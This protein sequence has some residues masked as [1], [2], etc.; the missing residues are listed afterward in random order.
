MPNLAK[1]V[2]SLEAQVQKYER[3][4]NRANRKLDQFNRKQTKS[5]DA[6]KKSFI[7]LGAAAG[8][9][10][11]GAGLG[12]QIVRIE[13]ATGV[14]RAQLETATGS[15]EGA[16]DAFDRL[17][18][19]AARTP[20]ALEESI[21][22]FTRLVNLGLTPS[23]RALVSYGNTAAAT[24]K[25]ILQFVEA[26][27]DASVGEFER[28]K[29]FGIKAGKEGDKVTFRFRGLTTEVGNSISEIENFLIGLGETEFGGGLERRIETLDGKLSN[30]GDAWDTLFRTISD[31][32]IGD[33]IKQQV[34]N[35]ISAIEGLNRALSSTTQDDLQRQLTLALAA[36]ADI[37]Q[38]IR[39]AEEAGVGSNTLSRLRR[40][41]LNLQGD[42][43]RIRQQLFDL[44]RAGDNRRSLE[45]FT[46][47]SESKTQ[48]QIEAEIEAAERL[49]QSLRVS[50]EIAAAGIITTGPAGTTVGTTTTEEN[51]SK[52]F[53]QF[54]K[55]NEKIAASRQN[56]TELFTDNL[57]QAADSG[58]DSIL[59][60]WAR[61]LQQMAAR[62]IASQVFN[63]L[64]NLGGG[65]AGTIGG[66]FGN[67]FGGSFANGG[68]VPGSLGQPR[69]IIAHGGE[70]VVPPGGGRGGGDTFHIDAR[71]AD[72]GTAS[73]IEELVGR[74]VAGA[75]EKRLDA[76]RRGI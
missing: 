42:L 6:I 21:T 19:F 53:E 27:A 50:R 11:G 49:Q 66:F 63:F 36:Q 35:A 54:D 15:V 47:Q 25:T 52:V 48:T 7:K 28:L 31:S 33:L 29:E 34:D 13:R 8:A 1:Y 55:L 22:A 62:L 5:L 20:F 59:E 56:F 16:A 51:A 71:G 43:V 18:Q 61:T 26:V 68:T 45:S 3:N 30:L 75:E 60:S 39:D 23:E 64:T 57:V 12:R 24:G 65:G 72:A 76:Q 74:A 73:L 17:E 67:I 37:S 69:L 32:G 4:L 70:R 44:Q 46:Q 10:L 2:V 38:K 14:L 40:A 41:A 58:F 9:A